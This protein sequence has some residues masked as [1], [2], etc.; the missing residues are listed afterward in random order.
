MKTKRGLGAVLLVV[1]V[2]A[3]YIPAMRGGFVW[4]DD[5]YV[6]NNQTLRNVDGLA[7]IWFQ[8]GAVPQ[9]Y[10]LVHTT[11]WVEYRL[12][13]LHPL[14]YHIVNVLLHA[15]AALLLIAVLERLQIPGAWLAGAI[16]A[17][18]PVQVESVAWITERKNVLSG[19]FYLLALLAYLRFAPLGAESPPGSNRRRSYFVSL[20]LFACALLAKTVTATLPAAILLLTWWK[21]GR[22]RRQDFAPLIP[23]FLIGLAA[24]SMTAWMERVHVGARGAEWDLSLPER[25]LV[26]GRAIWFYIAKTGW[27]ADLSFVY[28]RWRIHVG[29]VGQWFYPLAVLAVVAML[30]FARRRIGSGPL[31]GLLFYVGTLMP[32]LGFFDVYPMRYSFVADHFQYL[33]SMGLI[34]LATGAGVSAARRWS[35][36]RGGRLALTTVAV[37]LLAALGQASWHRGSVYLDL[38]T[39][40]RDTID[41]NPECWMAQHNLGMVYETRG[42]VDRAIVQYRKAV[43]IRPDL[44][45]SHF[46]L[47][48]ML[49]RAGD[50]SGARAS[51]EEALR[52]RPAY[53]EAWNNLGNVLILEEDAASAVAAYRRALALDPANASAHRNL[54]FALGKLG[55]A[56]GATE[57]L[58]A[59]LR[60]EP[61]DASA[62]NLLAWLLS[63]SPDDGLRDGAEA[64]RLAEA[65]SAAAEGK[66]MIFLRTLAAAYAEAG[67]FEDAVSTIDRAI[68]L[69]RAVGRFDVAETYR[70]YRDL[71]SSR[72][73]YRT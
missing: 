7:R 26:A 70:A 31:V 51:F 17:L 40:W 65:A 42:E 73:P 25:I 16:F 45:A 58:R 63:T 37:I 68:G 20:G 1:A 39:L 8:P 67:R 18:H 34:A 46:N 54:G 28:A 43:D 27:P 52:I 21:R 61:M 41:R 22:I 2:I 55:D 57:E 12:W 69:A 9:Y 36:S 62:M 4:D 10:P 71:F 15:A 44:E 35:R 32:A 64:V 72:R 29:N 3:T 5:E 33:A 13:G 24:G 47:G 19:V 60:L 11:F 48:T 6:V 38:E 30:T 59:S 49:A 66:D 14:G 53:T 50:L 56:H 23:F